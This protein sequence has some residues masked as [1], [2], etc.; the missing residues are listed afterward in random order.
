VEDWLNS[1]SASDGLAILFVLCR[2]WT[3]ERD[4]LQALGVDNPE[5]L[6]DLL[7]TGHPNGGNKAGQIAAMGGEVG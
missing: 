1:R 6:D 5:R 4:Q 3:F 7:V 2:Q